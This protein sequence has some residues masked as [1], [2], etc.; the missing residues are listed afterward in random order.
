MAKKAGASERRKSE[1]GVK[2]RGDGRDG[3]KQSVRASGWAGAEHRSGLDCGGRHFLELRL[4]GG[5]LTRTLAPPTAPG[6]LPLP[7]RPHLRPKLASLAP[8]LDVR[9]AN[10]NHNCRCFASQ[11]WSRR[12]G[13]HPS[14]LSCGDMHAGRSLAM[15]SAR[16]GSELAASV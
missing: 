4:W 10:V 8:S 14:M 3:V 9:W 11:S 1:A 13:N 5:A 2:E 12:G 6:G 7:F 15:T 16:S